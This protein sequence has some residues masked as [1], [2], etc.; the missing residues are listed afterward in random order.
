MSTLDADPAGTLRSI[1]ASLGLPPTRPAALHGP[2][3]SLASVG[4]SVVLV[5]FQLYVLPPAD[6]VA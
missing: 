6:T 2:A 4:T 5:A 3:H 1:P